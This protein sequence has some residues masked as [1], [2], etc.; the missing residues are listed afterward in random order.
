MHARRPQGTGRTSF[1][2]PV[3]PI[4]LSDITIRSENAYASILVV[5]LDDKPLAK[6]GQ[7]GSGRHA[8]PST[9]WADHAVTFQTKTKE[10]IRGRQ[11]DSTGK[12]PWVVQVTMATVEV[13]NL[14]LKSASLLDVNG[15]ATSKLPVKQQAGTIAVEL[16]SNAM[17]VVL[18]SE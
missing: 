17:Y 1:L 5:S 15:N 2:K 9:G 7:G 6:S 3:G 16:P 8:A 10:T 12:M 11:V 4:K 13:K 14:N 18:S